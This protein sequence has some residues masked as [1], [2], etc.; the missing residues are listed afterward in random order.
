MGQLR[1]PLPGTRHSIAF[2]LSVP[3]LKGDTMMLPRP[4]FWRRL[5]GRTR[6][7]RSVSAERGLTP[8]VGQHRQTGSIYLAGGQRFG[9]A[10]IYSHT[11]VPPPRPAPFQGQV[12]MRNVPER[13]GPSQGT[14]TW[15]REPLPMTS[16][17]LSS[18]VTRGHGSALA[19]YASPPVWG[20]R[21]SPGELPALFQTEKDDL[22][23]PRKH[24]LLVRGK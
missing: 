23:L 13:P 1:P 12:T 3:I 9:A 11:R 14:V 4:G 20:G 18:C 17:W 24:K 5:D 8:S 10:D 19:E 21:R 16:V 22:F 15:D 2:G 6:A 7:E